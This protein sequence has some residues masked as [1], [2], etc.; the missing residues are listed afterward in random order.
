MCWH[1]SVTRLHNLIFLREI[2]VGIQFVLSVLT[3]LLLSFEC[4]SRFIFVLNVLVV[5]L[6]GFEYPYWRIFRLLN[7][8]TQRC[9][10]NAFGR[11]SPLTERSDRSR[12]LD[13]SARLSKYQLVIKNSTLRGRQRH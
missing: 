10:N 1:F 8:E 11:T 13:L 2:M 7:N 12:E 4:S 3:G 5:P 9:F 6:I